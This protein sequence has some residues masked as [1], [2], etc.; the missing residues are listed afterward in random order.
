MADLKLITQYNEDTKS[1]PHAKKSE[2]FSRGYN[3]LKIN[4]SKGDLEIVSGKDKL[5]QDILKFL[6]TRRGENPGFLEYGTDFSEYVGQSVRE[7]TLGYL[8]T[9]IKDDLTT[10]LQELQNTLEEHPVEE[11]L[12]AMV[13]FD[14]S[15]QETTFTVNFTLLTGAREELTLTIIVTEE[16]GITIA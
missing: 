8:Q 1:L 5:K 3:D 4:I 15:F 10:G 12:G 14:V 6:V 7:G 13:N 16:G 2:F 9:K 11:Q